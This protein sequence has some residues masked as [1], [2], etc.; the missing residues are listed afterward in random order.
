MS[1]THATLLALLAVLLALNWS[2]GAESAAVARSTGN[3]KGPAGLP[4]RRIFIK[5]ADASNFFRRRNR[6]AVKSQD[7]LNAEQSQV[8]AADE[9]MREFHEEKRN[10]FENYAEEDHDEQNERTR[11][12]TEQWREFHYDGMDPPHEYNRHTA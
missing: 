8:L 7:E 5:E 10:K 11:E 4:L 6:R 1:W 12:S 9:R 3:A 2:P